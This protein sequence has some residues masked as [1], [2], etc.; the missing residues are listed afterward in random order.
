MLVSTS[1]KD[2]R[3]FNSDDDK[4]NH[5]KMVPG[6]QG[7]KSLVEYI[8]FYEV[9]FTICTGILNVRKERRDARS[10]IWSQNHPIVVFK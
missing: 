7:N 8:S 6:Y 4:I 2:A 5:I 1:G 3:T 9:A 10:K